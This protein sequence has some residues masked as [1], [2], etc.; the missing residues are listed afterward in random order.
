MEEDL[1]KPTRKDFIRTIEER[2]A[3]KFDDLQVAREDR[4]AL[5]FDEFGRS[6][7]ILLKANQRAYQEFNA[8]KEEMSEDLN[9]KYQEIQRTMNNAPDSITRQTI[10]NMGFQEADWL[11]RETYE[12]LIMDILIK[13]DLVPSA[14]LVKT[15]ATVLKEKPRDQTGPEEQKETQPVQQEKERKRPHLLNRTKEKFKV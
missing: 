7:E 12:E 10:G 11:F 8:E 4:N 3:S 1:S 5:Y 13:Y 2:L 6:I 9:R 14:Q 15:H